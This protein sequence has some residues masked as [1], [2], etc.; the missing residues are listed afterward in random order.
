MKFLAVLNRNEHAPEDNDMIIDFAA[1]NNS[2]LFKFKQQITGQTGN[3]HTKYVEILVLLEYLSNFW[4]TLEMRL[5]NYE[6]NFQ[7]KWSQICILVNSTAANQNPEF[8][9]HDTKVYVPVV[10]LSS[11]E[12]ITLLKQLECGF[13]RA[14]NWNKYLP[15]AINQ[16]QNRY[17]DFL[18]DPNFLGVNRL[19]VLSFKHDDGWES[20]K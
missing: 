5:I 2:A 10:T 16:A 15:K 18:I 8:Q 12:N 7:L 1:N 19:F 4:R 11:Q 17:L 3:C 13:K 14:I 9:I 20:H 6:I